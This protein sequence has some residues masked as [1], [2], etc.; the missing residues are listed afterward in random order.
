MQERRVF[1]SKRTNIFIIF[2]FLV[3]GLLISRL[4][5]L[6]IIHGAE[7]KTAGEDQYFFDTGENFN[8]G[9]VFFSN[10]SGISS[11]AIEMSNEYDIAID[12]K[13]V[14]QDL[15]KKVENDNLNIIDLQNDFYDKIQ[16]VFEKHFPKKEDDDLENSSSTK[17]VEFVT[18]DFFMDKI[19]D[20]SSSFEV[21]TKNI[22]EDIA[23]D[24]IDLHLRGLIIS[25]KKSRV[26]FE[27]GIAA[28]VLG[29]VGFTENTKTGLYGLE[30][31]YND[32]L[33]KEPITNVNFFA[34]VF[35]DFNSDTNEAKRKNIINDTNLEGDI[36]LTID[37]NVERYLQ[38]IL[39]KTKTEWKSQKVGGIVMDINDGSIIAMDEVPTFDPNDY[40]SVDD[41]AIYNNDLVSGV[42][43]MGSIIKPLTV[44]AALDAGIVDE[45]T[46]YND[47]G[48]VVLSGYKVSNFDKAARGPNTPIQEILSQSLNVG[49]AFL[50]QK[51]GGDKFSEYFHRFGL[52][53]YTGIDLPNETSGLVA[54]LDSNIVVDSVTAGFGQ[55]IAITPIQTIRALATLGNGGKLVTPH[56]VKSINYDNGSTKIIATDEPIEIFDDPSTSQRISKILTKVVDDAMHMKN[57]KYTVAAK[58]GT[59]QMVNPS[60]GKYYEDRYL[61]SFFGY[62]PATNPK[63]I[64]FLYQVYPQGAQYASQTLKNAFFDLVD[65]L[66]TYYEI[67]PDR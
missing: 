18:R 24:L 29:F 3:F 60:T 1:I 39:L 42:Y 5:Y 30:K 67:Q 50:V 44:A 12:P 8:R 21:L 10:K 52:G 22:P 36:N 23:N 40:K 35:S 43:E 34:E 16:K 62:F 64:I 48:T 38:S 32:I 61:H 2:I 65:Y 45:S 66:L 49:I 25:R 46:T 47:T 7:Y 14:A 11:P 55:G 51:M 56:V 37:I 58:T 13:T 54:N 20:T 28:K 31:Y 17:K 15:N 53:E 6:Q 63:Y 41:I 27:K 19:A 9:S 4:F 57:P 33:E 59:A 26:Y